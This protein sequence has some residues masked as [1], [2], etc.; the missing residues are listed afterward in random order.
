M[1]QIFVGAVRR[2]PKAPCVAALNGS[3][4]VSKRALGWMLRCRT[5]IT[6]GRVSPE[7]ASSCP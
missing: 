4:I 6:E 7:K 1:P 2:M 5:M 3:V